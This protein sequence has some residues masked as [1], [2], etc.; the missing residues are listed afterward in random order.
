MRFS[1][2]AAVQAAVARDKIVFALGEE[3]GNIWMTRL[4]E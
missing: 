2:T 3:T 4:P 1:N